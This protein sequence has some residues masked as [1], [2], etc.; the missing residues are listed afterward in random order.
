MKGVSLLK[1]KKKK[2]HLTISIS[3]LFIGHISVVPYTIDSAKVKI[4]KVKLKIMNII[5]S[6]IY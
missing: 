4:I 1:K 5:T 2:G 6:N 3:C